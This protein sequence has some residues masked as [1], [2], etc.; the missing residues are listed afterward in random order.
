MIEKMQLMMEERDLTKADVAKGVDIP[1]TTLDSLF[2]R[3]FENARYP[4]LQKLAKFFDV[5]MEYLITDE[6]E[7]R[8]YGKLNPFEIA[9][10]EYHLIF[11]WRKLP[12]DEQ[13]KFLGRIEAKVEENVISGRE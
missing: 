11:L 8:E 12:H 3:G 1:Y 4:T 5:S 10:E 9:K 6:E 2:R 7:D 13:M